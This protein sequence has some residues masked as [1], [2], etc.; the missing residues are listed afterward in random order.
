MILLLLFLTNITI[1]TSENRIKSKQISP[2]TKIA[3]SSEVSILNITNF[4]NF[5]IYEDDPLISSENTGSTVDFNYY[6]GAS[7]RI[8]ENYI[9]YLDD[10]GNCSYFDIYVSF[11]YTLGG[12]IDQVSFKLVT[13]SYY[14][15]LGDYM[16]LSDLVQEDRLLNNA[17]IWDAWG[18]SG[19]KYVAVG[20]PNDVKERYETTYGSIGFS[21][22]VTEHL[23]RNESGLYSE[24]YDKS[25]GD[26]LISHYWATGISKPV[27]YLILSFASGE[28]GSLSELTVYDLDATLYMTGGELAID[29]IKPSVNIIAPSSDT[30]I[31][32][33]DVAVVWT[34]YDL[35]SGLNGYYVRI[36]G[37]SWIDVGLDTIY[38]I[39]GLANGDHIV[40]VKAVDNNF[41]YFIAS[42]V[43]TIDLSGS[44]SN[45]SV[46]IPGFSISISLL[47]IGLIYFT[48]LIRRKKKG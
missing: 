15:Y 35:E 6:G 26:L 3:L 23:V 2:T 43:F 20:Y 16:G 37:S 29:S 19:G 41:N 30:I 18:E 12:I 1:F 39:N 40:E 4:N 14:N 9:L 28:T 17:G 32:S 31:T 34:G 22:G 24:Q 5:T 10:Y 11:N 42:T 38:I 25:T 36:D 13:A 45:P 7:E 44:I 21:G 48:I 46:T 8:S 33:E 47:S 27:N